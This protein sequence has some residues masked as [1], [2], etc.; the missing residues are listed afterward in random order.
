MAQQPDEPGTSPSLGELNFC[1][2]ILRRMLSVGEQSG[3]LDLQLEASRLYH[4]LWQ[5]HIL[6]AGSKGKAWQRRVSGM[7][8]PAASH[9]E[10]IGPDNPITRMVEVLLHNAIKCHAH[11]IMLLPEPQHLTVR[12]RIDESWKEIMTLPLFAVEPTFRLTKQWAE[13]PPQALPPQQGQ[14]FIFHDG[15]SYA[16]RVASQHNEGTET[17]PVDGRL[18]G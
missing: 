11:E 1:P 3:T 5:Y 6:A 15:Q 10:F 7:T 12:Y 13:I 18:P 14:L 17:L 8:L 2:V 9:W 4:D 16:V